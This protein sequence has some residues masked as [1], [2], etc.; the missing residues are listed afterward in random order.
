MQDLRVL[1]C[2]H[3]F[4]RTCVDQWLVSRRTCPL[5][6]YNIIEGKYDTGSLPC[7]DDPSV[8]EPSAGNHS[9]LP[10][11][12][13]QWETSHAQPAPAPQINSNSSRIDRIDPIF[14]PL[15]SSSTFFVNTNASNDPAETLAGTVAPS[16]GT[17][18]APRS[19]ELR[20]VRH[21]SDLPNTSPLWTYNS[22]QHCVDKNKNKNKCYGLVQ[23]RALAR[24]ADGISS[25]EVDQSTGVIQC[26]VNVEALKGNAN[27]FG[28]PSDA[29]ECACN[30]SNA[31]NC[32]TI[33]ST[34]DADL[35]YTDHESPHPA[36]HLQPT[37]AR[38]PS[39]N[40]DPGRDDISC[41]S[42]SLEECDHVHKKVKESK[43]VCDLEMKHSDRGVH[44]QSLQFAAERLLY[45][46]AKDNSPAK[47]VQVA[48]KSKTT[49]PTSLGKCERKRG[50]V[51]HVKTCHTK[52]E[53]LK[54][55]PL[56]VDLPDSS[57]E[58]QAS[59]RK[60]TKLELLSKSPAKT[61]RH[62]PGQNC[63]CTDLPPGVVT[64][65]CNNREITYTIPSGLQQG[66]VRF[67][68][69]DNPCHVHSP[70]KSSRYGSTSTNPY[71][72]SPKRMVHKSQSRQVN[73]HTGTEAVQEVRPAMPSVV[74]GAVN[75]SNPCRRSIMV[76]TDNHGEIFFII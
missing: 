23:A 48:S 36:V 58:W 43:N 73:I 8:S 71:V 40:G 62:D 20:R 42:T 60:N 66:E 57:P 70:S 25:S 12:I 29:A 13:P 3:E 10:S 1:P 28:Q 17:L 34:S 49:L 54:V 68:R 5:C 56:Y 47:S 33:A 16:R 41:S 19:S 59:P 55:E 75:T 74:E 76:Y 26:V 24:Y 39:V 72:A 51:E 50:L 7:N 27:S 64:Y 2:T 18:H 37:V 4:H 6:C 52:H 32:A 30:I 46:A 69:C 61:Q 45:I 35:S 22:P 63:N 14:A 21:V 11:Q 15:S 31:S 9:W 67:I 65:T 44:R 53:R 38:L